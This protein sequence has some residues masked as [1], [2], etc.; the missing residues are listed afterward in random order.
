[1]VRMA[2]AAKGFAAN[3]VVFQ[4]LSTS[5]LAIERTLNPPLSVLQKKETA[6]SGRKRDYYSIARYWWPDLNSVDGTGIPYVRFDG[7]A[8]PDASSDKYDRVALDTVL[9]TVLP[10]AASYFIT[11]ELGYAQKVVDQVRAWFTDATSGMMPHM[12]FA[13]RI[14]GVNFGSSGGLTEMW[15]IPR[16]LDALALVQDRYVMQSRHSICWVL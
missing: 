8:N 10:L 12:E 2:Y 11:G 4:L 14:I 13:Q 5:D 6:P 15:R 1:M 16:V 7:L 3:E 9:D